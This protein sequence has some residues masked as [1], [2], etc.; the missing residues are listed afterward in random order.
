MRLTYV[1]TLSA[2]EDLAPG[3][4]Q[5]LWGGQP[6]EDQA[7]NTGVRRQGYVQDFAGQ[8]KELADGFVSGQDQPTPGG[9]VS[10]MLGG[11]GGAVLVYDI[12]EDDVLDLPRIGVV[13][14]IHLK[15]RPSDQAASPDPVLMAE[16]WLAAGLRYL[17][18]RIRLLKGVVAVADLRVQT[19]EQE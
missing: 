18:V 8:L 5:L 3:S 13:R 4:A 6:T 10:L 1:P 9:T 17:P 16:V 11:A 12:L 7:V 2:D 15:P 14:A 19:I